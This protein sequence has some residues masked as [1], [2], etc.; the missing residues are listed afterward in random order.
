VQAFTDRP[1]RQVS[2]Q[3]P[4]QLV[5]DWSSY[6]FDETPPNASVV[7]GSAAAGDKPVALELADP[8]WD[9]G[10]ATLTYQA[11]ILG[12]PGQ[13]ADLPTSFG[14]VSVFV[15][16]G[17]DGSNL[18]MV[19]IWATLASD[20]DTVTIDLDSG[21]SIG[22]F[23]QYGTIA[24]YCNVE[25]SGEA[26][27]ACTAAWQ[28]HGST[29]YLSGS[30]SDYLGQVPAPFVTTKQVT[31]GSVM[32]PGTALT[33]TAAL[34]SGATLSLVGPNGTPVPVTGGA[35]SVDVNPG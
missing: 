12:D 34:S 16:S 14:Q 2:W 15:D 31:F 32:V 3:S 9:A 4:Q 29:L 10:T 18:G 30:R 11:S 24:Q 23:F 19:Q 22:S 25:E 28:V 35:F 8:T 17:I 26:T 33:G 21:M 27:S 20:T 6:G 7:V 1:D 5:D 13:Q